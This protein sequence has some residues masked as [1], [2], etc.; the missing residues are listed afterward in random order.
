MKT[1]P[2]RSNGVGETVVRKMKQ[3]R[4]TWIHFE[5]WFMVLSYKFWQDQK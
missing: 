3:E 1:Y 2:R 5:P 4:W